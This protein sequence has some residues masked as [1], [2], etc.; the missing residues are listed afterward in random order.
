ML[1]KTVVELQEKGGVFFRPCHKPE[2]LVAI[3]RDEILTS[4]G[5]VWELSLEDALAEDWIYI[6]PKESP[7]RRAWHE[8]FSQFPDNAFKHGW[9]A[10]LEE[11]LSNTKPVIMCKPDEVSALQRL[12]SKIRNLRE[13][14]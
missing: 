4:D 3:G 10:A 8:R 7:C 9:N 12:F 6:G 5:T 11:I 1:F 2:T 13:E 14:S